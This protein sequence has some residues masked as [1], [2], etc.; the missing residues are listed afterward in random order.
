MY[1]LIHI[2]VFIYI[3]MYQCKHVLYLYISIHLGSFLLRLVVRNIELTAN[4]VDKQTY[5]QIESVLQM[6]SEQKPQECLSNVPAELAFPFLQDRSGK[7][8]SSSESILHT[9]ELALARF[10]FP[11]IRTAIVSPKKPP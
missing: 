7:C 11:E 1:T 3:V 8:R 5:P 4:S 2:C 9:N 10:K 6:N